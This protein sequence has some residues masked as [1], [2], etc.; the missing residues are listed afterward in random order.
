[1]KIVK[2]ILYLLP[3]LLIFF[4]YNYLFTT[5]LIIDEDHYV[6]GSK[7]ALE[8]WTRSRAYPQKD[9]PADKFYKSFQKEK[10]ARKNAKSGS[11]DNATWE[12]MGPYNVPGRML[13]VA[14][15]PLDTT[16]VL[17]GSASG[18]LWRTNN[19]STISNWKR[20]HTGFPVLGVMTIAI[21]P[22]DT[23]VIYICKIIVLVSRS[24]ASTGTVDARNKS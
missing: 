19:A 3:L 7:K 17:A 20:I 14:V 10:I 6:P 11:I 18:G 13:S 8:F 2:V 22:V 24:M 9:I 16:V 4:A 15:N 12:E 5:E 23:N 1:M 21:N